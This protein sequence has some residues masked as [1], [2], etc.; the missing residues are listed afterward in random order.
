MGIECMV[1]PNPAILYPAIA[2][3]FLTFALVCTMGAN[4]LR[5]V[6]SREVSITYYRLYDEGSEPPRLRRITRHVQNHFEVPP[7]FHIVVVLLYVTHLAGALAVGLAWLYFA[8]RC[9]HSYIHL[10]SNNVTRRFVTYGSSGFVLAALWGMLL[11]GLLSG[12]C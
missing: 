12:A 2:M 1:G 6:R 8:L 10:G 9:V 7:L 5:G 4:R 3:F 11:F